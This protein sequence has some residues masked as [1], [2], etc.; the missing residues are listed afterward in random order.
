MCVSCILE[1]WEALELF[2]VAAAEKE[3]LVSAENIAAALKNPVI[4]MYFL[5]LDYVLPMFT[6]FNR[7]FQSEYPNM[8]CL[9]KELVTLYKSLLSCYMTNAY[10][11]S[12]AVGLLD[13]TSRQNMVSLISM[14][15][16]QGVS[17]S[18]TKPEILATKVEMRGYLEHC[19]Q[20]FIEA[21]MQ[22]KKRFPISDSVLSSLTFLDP[23]TFS[24]AQCS[25]VIDVASKFPNIIDP[26]DIQKLDSEW[27]E[28]SFTDL[29]DLPSHDP[30]THIDHFWGEIASL[31]DGCGEAKFPTIANSLNVTQFEKSDLMAT[32]CAN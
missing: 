18:L 31:S 13:P 4:K 5:F 19:Q 9:T 2:F 17:S 12:V 29:G 27:R 1:Q 10:I 15:M 30:K 21:A 24:S 6:K 25:A 7:L 8:H 26:R 28:L 16:G 23:A 22:V 14:S 20:F 32:I 3:Q 11:K